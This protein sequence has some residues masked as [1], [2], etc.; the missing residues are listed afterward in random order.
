MSVMGVKHALVMQGM[1]REQE[2]WHLEWP[3]LV[4]SKRALSSAFV[5][6]SPP[7]VALYRSQAPWDLQ[8]LAF[9]YRFLLLVDRSGTKFASEEKQN[10]WLIQSFGLYVAGNLSIPPPDIYYHIE[11]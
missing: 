3:D 11:F 9:K 6:R 2:N 7:L 5:P 8:W 4:P 10:C 1:Y